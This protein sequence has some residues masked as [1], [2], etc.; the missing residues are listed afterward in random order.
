MRTEVACGSYGQDGRVERTGHSYAIVPE[1]TFS[2]SD[3]SNHKKQNSPLPA[4]VAPADDSPLHSELT[5]R[6]KGLPPPAGAYKPSSVDMPW[7][8]D[9]LIP[10]GSD[11]IPVGRAPVAFSVQR[12][13]ML[14]FFCL[15]DLL[16]ESRSTSF[17]LA[18][19]LSWKPGVKSQRD[20]TERRYHLQSFAGS[21]RNRL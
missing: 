20:G 17:L 14:T 4:G 10:A 11:P 1:A 5:C 13:A 18:E 3:L 8:T 15:F 9:P 16:F 6:L 19:A 2:C 12:N 21:R 7:I